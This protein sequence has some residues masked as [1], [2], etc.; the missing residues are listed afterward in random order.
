M[1]VR[2]LCLKQGQSLNA[3]AAPPYPRYKR[4]LLLS[5][6]KQMNYDTRKYFSSFASLDH[7]VYMYCP[8]FLK[9]FCQ[10]LKKTAVECMPHFL[11]LILSREFGVPETVKILNKDLGELKD[12]PLLW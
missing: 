2:E 9:S 1:E 5:L 10:F 12:V 8:M 11:V 4:T 3:R 6:S 7:R